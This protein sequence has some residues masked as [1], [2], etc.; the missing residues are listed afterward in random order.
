[1]DLFVSLYLNQLF[2][3]Q[4]VTEPVSMKLCRCT[5]EMLCV[6]IILFVTCRD[7]NEK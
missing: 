7:E 5:L 3:M 1:M 4:K 2:I 6:I